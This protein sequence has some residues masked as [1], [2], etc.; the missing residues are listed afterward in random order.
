MS[1]ADS[2]LRVSGDL[3]AASSAEVLRRKRNCPR[4]RNRSAY[5]RHHSG[6]QEEGEIP[7]IAEEASLSDTIPEVVQP[8]QGLQ[9]LHPRL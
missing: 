3:Q 1:S 8:V 2:A 5:T 4:S 7:P 6:I 9:L